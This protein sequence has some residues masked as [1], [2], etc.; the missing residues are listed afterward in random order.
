MI[1]GSD[2]GV[3]KANE[4]GE[5]ATV[6]TLKWMA[7]TSGWLKMNWEASIAKDKD[8]MGFGMVLQDEKGLLV[9]RRIAR[10]SSEDLMC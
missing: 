6:A 10:L 5:D 4:L 1:N 2:G 8:W 9:A 3:L 7:P